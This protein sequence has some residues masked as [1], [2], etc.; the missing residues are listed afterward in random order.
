MRHG[1]TV[2]WCGWQA[3][4]PASPGLI[5]LQ[6]PEAIGPGGPLTGRILCQFQSNET[7]QVFLLADRQHVPHPPV[8]V[9]DPS[10]ALTVRDDPNSPAQAISRESWSFV[11]VE[12]EQVEPEPSHVYMPAGVRARPDLSAG[13]QHQGQQYCRARLRRGQGYRVVFE[14]RPGCA[15]AT[16]APAPSNMPTPWAGPRVAGSC[17]R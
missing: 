5:G 14:A 15:R 2:V 9:D 6:A 7:T 13:L 16:P 12:D 1:Y 10:A 11:R 4:V 17:V 8:D 3:D